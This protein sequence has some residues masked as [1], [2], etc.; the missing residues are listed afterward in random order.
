MF[1]QGN[2]VVDATKS[3]AT[4]FRLW[5]LQGEL[6]IIKRYTKLAGTTEIMGS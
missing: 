3:Y 4:P 2:S 6:T 5:H 1:G